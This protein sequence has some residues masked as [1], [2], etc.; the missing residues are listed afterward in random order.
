[1]INKVAII[2]SCK[3][4][5][6]SLLQAVKSLY[7]QVDEIRIAFNGYEEIPDWV[8]NYSKIISFLFPVDEYEARAVWLCTKQMGG[9]ILI[10]DDDI[11]YPKDYAHKMI[12]LIEKYKR[13][14]VV[15]SHGS[16]LTLPYIKYNKSCVFSHFKFALSKTMRVD[17]GGVGTLVY[18]TDTIKPNI[19]DFPQS[20]LRDVQ[21]GILCANKHIDIIC[22]N[23]PDGWLKPIPTIGDCICN[24]TD[25]ILKES[26]IKEYIIPKIKER[27][28]NVLHSK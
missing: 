10:A 15:V 5:S 27:K 1:M 21:F 17:I 6:A 24:K 2:A 26:L 20:Y 11:I 12:G 13:K 14:I 7:D 9:Y 8:K 18:H 4:R 25:I 16:A 19:N 28:I 22:I 3:E 23:R